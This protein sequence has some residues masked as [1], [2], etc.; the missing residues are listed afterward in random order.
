LLTVMFA[1]NFMPSILHL[2]WSPGLSD[3][4]DLELSS[5][6]SNLINVVCHCGYLEKS[7]SCRILS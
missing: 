4:S 7:S 6:S 2:T 5:G 3:G 1:T